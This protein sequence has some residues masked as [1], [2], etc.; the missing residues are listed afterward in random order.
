M[1][2]ILPHLP[3]LAL[4]LGVFVVQ[5]VQHPTTSGLLSNTLSEASNGNT[6]EICAKPD[7]FSKPEESAWCNRG[8][9]SEIEEHR[10]TWNWSCLVGEK[11]YSCHFTEN[12]SY[13]TRGGVLFTK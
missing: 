10:H 7:Q 13:P 1:Q 9:V 12:V 11:V 3:L 5:V 6:V 2:K 8:L 4:V